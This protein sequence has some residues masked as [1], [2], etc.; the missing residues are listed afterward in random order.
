MEATLK[1]GKVNRKKAKISVKLTNMENE[2]RCM[3]ENKL[4]GLLTIDVCN[5]L[6]L[7]FGDKKYKDLNKKE[8]ALTLLKTAHN[9]NEE[10]LKV[11]ENQIDTALKC[12]NIK[13]YGYFERF[14]LK[15]VK[16]VIGKSL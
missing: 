14:F 1:L 9:L 12:K 7:H 4:D 11:V 10:E 5:S 6:E 13:Q 15:L 8:L 2:L 3:S 16:K